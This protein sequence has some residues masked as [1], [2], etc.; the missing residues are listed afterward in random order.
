MHPGSTTSSLTPL[1]MQRPARS[2][3]ARLAIVVAILAAATV[4]H[5]AGP[6]AD[7]ELKRIEA[8]LNRL[9]QAQQS[10]FQQFQMVQE[11]RRSELARPAPGAL[12]ATGIAPPPGNYEDLQRERAQREQ[13]LK[14]LQAETER[15]YAHYQALEEEKRGLLER[16]QVLSQ[17]H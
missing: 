9:Q 17:G 11:L 15:L 1:I 12:P 10:T 4:T 14:D 16:M 8:T 3:L 13:R 6:E 2:S 7:A 5:A